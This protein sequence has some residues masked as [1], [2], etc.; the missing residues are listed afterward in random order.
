M[1]QSAANSAIHHA[2]RVV[3]PLSAHGWRCSGVGEHQCF[4]TYMLGDLKAAAA[5]VGHPEWGLSGP[6]DAGNYNSRSWET[7]FFKSQGGRWQ[8]DYGHFFQSWYRCV[9]REML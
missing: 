9:S 7:G 2:N 3:S 5:A 4:D 1:K 8:S 6:H